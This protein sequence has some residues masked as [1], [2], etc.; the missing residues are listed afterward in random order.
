MNHDVSEEPID[1]PSV[2]DD[3]TEN[4][5]HSVRQKKRK[6]KWYET[7]KDSKRRKSERLSM[8]IKPNYS[9]MTLDES[10][11]RKR[12]SLAVKVLVEKMKINKSAKKLPSERVKKTRCK[13]CASCIREDC[14]KCIYCQDMK[15]YGGPGRLKQKCM[16]KKCFNMSLYN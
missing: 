10:L 16:Y 9:L 12:K 3:N 11:S 13:E 14:R 15:R 8:A 7:E 5:D 1:A 6:E 4:I 2:L